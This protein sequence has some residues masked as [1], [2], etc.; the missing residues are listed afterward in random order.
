[1][2]LVDVAN[3]YQYHDDGETDLGPTIATLSLGG[4]AEMLIRMK[5]KYFSSKRFNVNLQDANMDIV[6]GCQM[7]EDRMKLRSAYAS[8]DPEEIR[9]ALGLFKKRLATEDRTKL[10]RPCLT[11]NLRHG[12][13]VVMHGAGTQK[14]FEVSLFH[15]PVSQV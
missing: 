5:E 2:N 14:F 3:F 6:P 1:M 4:E 10:A 12:D 7:Y 15:K 9:V 8:R 13:M 11:L